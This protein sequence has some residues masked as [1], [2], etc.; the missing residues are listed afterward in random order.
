[1][2]LQLRQVRTQSVYV[3]TALT[4]Q[5]FVILC[6]AAAP[7]FHRSSCALDGL[8]HAAGGVLDLFGRGR[9]AIADVVDGLAGFSGFG[10]NRLR[11]APGALLYLLEALLRV[12]FG[13]DLYVY[14]VVFD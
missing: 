12:V 9:A 14:A 4:G 8:N 7:R 3:D 5:R 10:R 11:H 1:Y 6:T 2:G 13:G